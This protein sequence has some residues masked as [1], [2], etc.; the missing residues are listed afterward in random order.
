MLSHSQRFVPFVPSHQITIMAAT[1]QKTTASAPGKILLAGGY[2]VLEAPNVGFVVA[3]DKR[4]YSTVE[5][6]N[7]S[8][9]GD[10]ET[11]ITVTSPQFHME[12]K[13]SYNTKA[14]T[15]HASS[16]NPSVNPFVEKTLHVCL[17]YL[18]RQNPNVALPSAL[19]ITIKADNDF[20]SVLP[21]LPSC[22]GSLAAVPQLSFGRGRQSRRQQDGFG[23][24]GGLD[25]QSRRSTGVLCAGSVTG[26]Q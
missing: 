24:V 20:Y 21:H 5:A 19:Q 25:H 2:L 7:S 17:L 22:G 14:H 4:F 3:A 18:T 9:N 12:W 26:E 13:Y 10:G 8:D 6:S 16:D 23:I 1:F 15:L 11:G